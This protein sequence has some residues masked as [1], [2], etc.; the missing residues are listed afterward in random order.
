MSETPYL[1]IADRV[2]RSLCRDA[3]WAD[4]RCNWIGWSMDTVGKM[5]ATV[6]RSFGPDLYNGTAGVALF[7]ARLY[8]FTEDP[9]VKKTLIGALNQALS[10]L[11]ALPEAG[12]TSFYSGLAGIAYAFVEAGEVLE[13]DA[14]IER[15][16]EVFDRVADVPPTGGML[17]VLSGSAGLI[18]A[19]LDA[20]RR[21]DRERYRE[22]AVAHARYLLDRADRT[23][24]GWSWRTMD[25]SVGQ[26]L[27]GY[28]HGVAGIAC[29]L[30]E[31][32]QATGEASFREGALNA[33]RYEQTHF[34]SEYRNWPD[35]RQF[36][37]TPTEPS[38]MVAWCHG[39]AGIGLARL[40]M[41]ELLGDEASVR[42]D[43][44]AAVQTTAAAL[45]VPVVSGQGNFS[46]CHGSGGNADLLLMA[47]QVFERPELLQVV[48]VVGQQ[49]LRLAEA[50]M[51]WP[52]GVQNAG[53]T[54]G[55]MLGLAGIGYFYLRLHSAESVPSV[56]ILRPPA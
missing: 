20:A 37:N 29:A 31:V 9:V 28:S 40:R 19:L 45:S 6:Y 44:E 32:Y 52:C 34:S 24:V 53:E 41:Y 25:P 46:L 11:D 56:L 8:R 1:D 17:D 55:L 27:L 13:H 47:S 50:Q 12:R 30:A 33:L 38:Y 43:I 18:P 26:N 42:D 48:E 15:G 23:D 5:W 21:F 54:P 35:F 2:G 14:L 36:G 39:A 7:L 4:G 51:P 22:A 16:R 49:G 10:R 3:L